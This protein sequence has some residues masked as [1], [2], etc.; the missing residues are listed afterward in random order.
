MWPHP[1][2]LKCLHQLTN[3]LWIQLKCLMIIQIIYGENL[4]MNQNCIIDFKGFISWQA[5]R[6]NN[7]SLKKYVNNKHSFLYCVV[8]IYCNRVGH[9]TSGTP[10]RL[11]K[12]CANDFFFVAKSILN[13]YFYLYGT[14]FQLTSMLVTVVL[15]ITSFCHP[16]GLLWC[17]VNVNLI[18]TECQIQR[19]W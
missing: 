6:R 10:K 1:G 8:D 18:H 4:E 14:V 12:I 11:M 15:R 19:T 17:C 16:N 9:N 7:I 5:G 13:H 3:K 2:I